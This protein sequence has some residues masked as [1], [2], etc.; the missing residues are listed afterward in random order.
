MH[1]SKSTDSVNSRVKERHEHGEEDNGYIITVTGLDQPKHPRLS[2]WSKNIENMSRE[3]I[4]NTNKEKAI[5]EQKLELTKQEL[6]EIK[7]SYA[8]YKTMTDK[9][10]KALGSNE[11]KDDKQKD[12]E[13]QKQLL[14]REIVEI[15]SHSQTEMH[16]LELEIGIYL[17]YVN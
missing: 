1:S 17:V 3:A 15:R 7:D 11:E 2:E 13:V 8:E 9:M 10:F 12:W 14:M 4:S 6:K 16:K 5:L